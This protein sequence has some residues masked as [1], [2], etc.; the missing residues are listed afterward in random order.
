MQAVPGRQQDAASYRLAGWPL[1]LQPEYI[2]HQLTGFG[3]EQNTHLPE[4]NKRN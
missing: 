4:F 1:L 2:G 3:I